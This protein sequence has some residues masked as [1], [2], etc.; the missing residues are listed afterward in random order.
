MRDP[1]NAELI[2]AY[3]DGEL[4]DDERHV[5]EQQLADSEEH[6]QL[7]EEL[8]GVRAD[9]QALP[10]LSP[11]SDLQARI[12]AQIEE[13]KVAPAPS[14][15]VNKP[16]RRHLLQAAAVVITTTA[17]AIALVLIRPSLD[18][19]SIV[20]HV[21]VH[22]QG[23]VKATF[24]MVYD[25]TVTEDGAKNDAFAKLLKQLEIGLDP[26]MR[27]DAQL[28]N[29]L[30]AFRGK[31]DDGQVVPFKDPAVKDS[32]H[33]EVEMIY[34]SGKAVKIE[35]LGL[36]LKAMERVG[37]DVSRMKYDLAFENR[38]LKLMR[39]LRTAARD[40][41][42]EVGPMGPSADGYAFK[43]RIRLVNAGVPGVAAFS[44]PKVD[45]TLSE[46]VKTA[47]NTAANGTRPATAST[48]QVEEPR[49]ASSAEAADAEA[50]RIGVNEKSH[51]LIILRKPGEKTE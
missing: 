51:V 43:F 39:T 49:R 12:T 31:G 28:E 21:P 36:A 14:G 25:V 44:L 32:E 20:H 45:A 23:E 50:E 4:S 48:K 29:K 8:E 33:D 5:V 16:H 40:H 35:E 34:I 6:R 24:V 18:H 38:Q 41:F 3:L 26:N 42:V 13:A 37:D 10:R 46:S 15:P 11:P 17:A 7:L 30:S 1:V 9:L 22:L 47:P 27:L 2:S 19:P